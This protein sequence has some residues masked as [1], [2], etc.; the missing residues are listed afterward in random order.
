M[1]W[2]VEC[3]RYDGVPDYEYKRSKITSMPVLDNNDFVFATD[4]PHVSLI[5]I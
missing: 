4:F 2:F 5:A 1:V 3:V